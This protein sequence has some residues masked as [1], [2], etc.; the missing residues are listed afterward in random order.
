MSAFPETECVV[1]G[2]LSMMLRMSQIAGVA[3]LSFRRTH[4]G[5]YIRTSRAANCYGKVLSFCLWFLSS[6]TI[7][8]DIIIEPERSFRTRTNSTRIVWLAD[9]ATVAMV[10]LTAA[11]TG[12]SRMTCL[13]V[14]ALKLEEI[15]LRLSLFHEEPTNEANRRLIAVSSMIFVVST[16]L[17]DY[18]IFIYQVVTDHGKIVTSCM[19]I[20]YNISTIVQQVILVTFSE[21]VTSVLTSLQMLNNCLK[22]LLQ[23]ILDNSAL[24]NYALKYDS[25]INMNPNM[26]TISNKSINSV[27]D[28]MAVYKGHKKS[29]L[30]AVPSTVRRLALLYCSICDVIRLVNDSHGLIIGALMLCLLLHLV[31]TPYHVITNIFNKERSDRSSPLLQLNW[32]VLHFVNLLLIVEPCHRTNEQIDQTRHLISQMIRYTS[33]EHGALLAELQMF[34]QHLILN[35]VSYAPLK[36]FSLNRSLIVTMLGSITTYLVVVVQ[37]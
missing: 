36:M 17:V 11:F 21:T 25:P 20:F 30:K 7:A 32:A 13:L 5:W 28:T 34:Y 9:V 14:Y 37:L 2:T 4:G 12:I 33:S 27:V 18:G 10:V 35:E 3:P 23:E 29:S 31:I 26:S 19:Y 1:T 6:F 15:N 8:I 24:K 22:N 16:I